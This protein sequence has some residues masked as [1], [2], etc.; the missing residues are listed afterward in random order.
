VL[1]INNL[2]T[3]Y[4]KAYIYAGGLLKKKISVRGGGC[5]NNLWVG[6]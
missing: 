4:Q 1:E 2:S 5:E 6:Y 3:I